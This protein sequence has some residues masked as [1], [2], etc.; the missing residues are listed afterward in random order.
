[1]Q[2]HPIWDSKNAVE[3]TTEWYQAYYESRHVLSAEHIGRYIEDAKNKK[4]G[5]G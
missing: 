3:K 1:M 4:T 5:M 2:W